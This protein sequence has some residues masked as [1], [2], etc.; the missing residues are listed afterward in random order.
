[1]C[2][3]LLIEMLHGCLSKSLIF[4]LKNSHKLEIGCQTVFIFFIFFFP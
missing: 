2:M 3:S 1:M 4:Y